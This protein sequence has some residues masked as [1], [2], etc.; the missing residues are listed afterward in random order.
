[1]RKNLGSKRREIPTE[2]RDTI[3]N[4]F[5]NVENGGS[6][7]SDVSKIFD[8]EDFGYR[9]IKVER[10]LRLSF[11]ATPE[12][13]EKLKTEKAFL[14]LYPTDQEALLS[15]L[16]HLPDTLFKNRN[17]FEKALAQ[18]LK[19]AGTKVGAPITKATHM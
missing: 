5:H 13:I 19:S 12:R 15:A 7:W 16:P 18:V 9:E 17:A 4:I 3:I 14:R 1:M 11:Q 10:P 6:E 8:A 2:A